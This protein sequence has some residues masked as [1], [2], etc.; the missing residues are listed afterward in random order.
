M[1]LLSPLLS[2]ALARSLSRRALVTCWARRAPTRVDA[3]HARADLRLA[4]LQAV[5][6]QPHLVLIL[7]VHN[8]LPCRRHGL[9]NPHLPGWRAVRG[10]APADKVRGI[11]PPALRA[12]GRWIFW[13]VRHRPVRWAELGPRLLGHGEAH[14]LNAMQSDYGGEQ[15]LKEVTLASWCW[16]ACTCPAC[17]GEYVFV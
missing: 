6:L 11:G 13:S 9:G 15:S 2:L 4:I 3:T 16:Q 14:F 17:F 7:F 1:R 5:T 8:S 10:Y 12:R